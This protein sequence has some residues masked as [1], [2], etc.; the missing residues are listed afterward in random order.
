MSF[1]VRCTKLEFSPKVGSPLTGARSRMVLRRMWLGQML[2]LKGSQEIFVV[3]E[4]MLFLAAWVLGVFAAV[5]DYRMR[6]DGK[7]DN[8]V[9]ATSN[10]FSG[11]FSG[12]E[13]SGTRS[14]FE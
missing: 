11:G 3:G 5:D 12:G 8:N 6:T 14:E 4:L 1:R 2:K 13:F 7:T 9:V 10:N